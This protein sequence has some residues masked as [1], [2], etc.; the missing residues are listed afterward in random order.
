MKV[1]R[2]EV[3]IR[4]PVEW[5]DEDRE[6]DLEAF[7][8]QDAIEVARQY[9]ADGDEEYI[10]DREASYVTVEDKGVVEE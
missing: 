6:V 1:R 5:T 3:T 2:F 9:F 7:T 10:F 4:F 8:P